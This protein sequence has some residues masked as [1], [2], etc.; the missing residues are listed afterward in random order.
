MKPKNVPDK[1]EVSRVPVKETAVGKTISSLRLTKRYRS[2]RKDL[3]DQLERNSTV[4]QYYHDLVEDYMDMWIEKCLAMADISE[5]GVIVE[6][7]NGGGQAGMTLA[8]VKAL[9]QGMSTRHNTAEE[10]EDLVA[11]VLAKNAVGATA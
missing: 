10:E 7:N 2:I 9:A 1:K 5:R 6:Y 3:L 11:K 4:G 8:V